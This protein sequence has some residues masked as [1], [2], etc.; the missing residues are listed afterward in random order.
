MVPLAQLDVSPKADGHPY[1]ALDAQVFYN[2]ILALVDCPR[3]ATAL[4]L[5]L[6]SREGYA[7]HV[8]GEKVAVIERVKKLGTSL[9]NHTV[10]LPRPMSVETIE[11]R[12][13]GRFWRY[14]INIGHLAIQ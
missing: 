7:I 10:S 12:A 13:L 5:S 11:I 14:P 4:Q 1:V 3:P 2:K 6:G 9:Q 8:N